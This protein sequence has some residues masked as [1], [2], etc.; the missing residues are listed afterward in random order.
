[1]P[2]I[3]GWPGTQG[4]FDGPTL[5]LT[6]ADS[7]Y[8]QPGYRDTIRGLFPAARF[9]KIPGTGHWLHAE[10][11]REFEDTVRVFLTA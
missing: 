6:G 10:K 5:F 11:P 9:A 7:H 4:S 1:M 8:V 2:K 3:V